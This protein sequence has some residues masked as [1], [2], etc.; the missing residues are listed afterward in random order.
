MIS[1]PLSRNSRGDAEFAV[2]L[3][4]IA[5][6][7]SAG[8]KTDGLCCILDG[9]PGGLRTLR[10]ILNSFGD[11]SASTLDSLIHISGTIGRLCKPVHS[12][13]RE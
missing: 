3:M 12:C 2:A 10:F 9:L 8:K 4:R 13:Q 1:W 11:P 5:I 6:P 7:I